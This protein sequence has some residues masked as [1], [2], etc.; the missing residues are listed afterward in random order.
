MML[1]EEFPRARI[2]EAQG[3]KKRFAQKKRIK[4]KALWARFCISG[5][6]YRMH[7]AREPELLPAG[8]LSIGIKNP[9]TT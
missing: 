4:K 6:T 9:A 8:E 7:P 1:G 3:L 2:C 5:S